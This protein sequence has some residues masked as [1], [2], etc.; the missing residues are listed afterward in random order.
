MVSKRER[1]REGDEDGGDDEDTGVGFSGLKPR[2]GERKK[3][4]GR[5]RSW[6]AHVRVDS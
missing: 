6:K 1:E 2:R 5:M 3:L 4:S